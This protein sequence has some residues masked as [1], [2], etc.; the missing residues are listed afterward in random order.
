MEPSSYEPLDV[1]LYLDTKLS[2]GTKL[3]PDK[4]LAV[5]KHSLKQGYLV[6]KF[7][8]PKLVKFGSAM[9][10]PALSR[11][12][13]FFKLLNFCLAPPQTYLFVFLSG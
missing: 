2:Q 6:R 3:S 7:F 4:I 13:G 1:F 5:A 10:Y 12:G 9:F 11:V 8:G